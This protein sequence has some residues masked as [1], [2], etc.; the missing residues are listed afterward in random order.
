MPDEITRAPQQ[1][2]LLDALPKW[3][4]RKRG[5]EGI[6][7]E[8]PF[9]LSEFIEGGPAIGPLKMVGGAGKYIKAA[10]IKLKS[11]KIFEGPSHHLAAEKFKGKWS[12]VDDADGFVTDAGEFLTREQAVRALPPGSIGKGTED[13]LDIVNQPVKFKKSV[14]FKL[15]EVELQKHERPSQ[16]FF[17]KVSEDIS[18]AAELGIPDVEGNRLMGAIRNNILK[19]EDVLPILEKYMAA[20][21]KIDLS[22]MSELDYM[23]LFGSYGGEGWV[24]MMRR[25]YKRYIR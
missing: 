6:Y 11:G 20:D 2:T 4:T 9:D 21:N 15:R 18:T 24:E 14:D 25:R 10:A 1:R 23:K 19:R 17:R 16:T 13:A 7:A 5:E 8:P 3:Y 12:E 22:K